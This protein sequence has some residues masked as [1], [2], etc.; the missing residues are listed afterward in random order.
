MMLEV[1][2]GSLPLQRDVQNHGEIKDLPMTSEVGRGRVGPNPG[3]PVSET[4][5]PPLGMKLGVL[6]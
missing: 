4:V 2:G 5:I 3:S 1:G 6:L